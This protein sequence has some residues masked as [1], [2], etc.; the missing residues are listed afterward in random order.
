MQVVEG[1]LIVPDGAK[2]AIVA[3]RFNDLIVDRLIAGAVDS[4]QRHGG[5]DSDLVLVRVPGA[6]EIPLA[7]SRLCDSGQFDGI[8]ALA[9]V[10]RGGTP[11]FDYVAAEVSKGVAHASLEAGVPVAFGVLTTD[12]IEQAV[13][14]AGTKAGNKGADAMGSVIEMISLG[15]VLDEAIP[16]VL[17]S[18]LEELIEK[19]VASKT[20]KALKAKPTKTR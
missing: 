9:A 7:V 1:Q 11:H 14:R 8:V 10:I 12:S 6:W 16:D 15:H 4:F 3:S 17:E 5:S 2:V 19:P 20:Q 13:E 18:E